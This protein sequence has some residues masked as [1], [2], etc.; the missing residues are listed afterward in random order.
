MFPPLRDLGVL[1]GHAYRV[2]LF[3]RVEIPP[4]SRRYFPAHLHTN[5]DGN[6]VRYVDGACAANNPTIV[7]LNHAK[8]L[9]KL[10]EEK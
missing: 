5:I 2:P 9:I 8:S 3:S 4:R 7:A 6:E 1:L 10:Q